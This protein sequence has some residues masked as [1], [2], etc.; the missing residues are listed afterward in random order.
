MTSV[1][2]SVRVPSAADGQVV[3]K[4]PAG[5]ARI[6]PARAGVER[7]RLNEK[8]VEVAVVVVVEERDAG[9][10]LLGQVVLAGRAVDVGEGEAGGGRDST[11]SGSAGGDAVDASRH[12]H[13]AWR[14]RSPRMRAAPS[15]ERS[16][17]HCGHVR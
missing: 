9:A 11:K 2:C 7:R 3:A 15:D 1:K 4:Q 14:A 13:R 5:R 10:H 12:R 8:D 16:P 17:A 6:V